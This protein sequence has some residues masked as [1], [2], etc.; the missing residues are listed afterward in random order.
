MPPVSPASRDR[1]LLWTLALTVAGAL[2]LLPFWQPLLLGVWAGIAG[3]GLMRRL[4]PLCRGHENIAATL[5]LLGIVLVAAPVIAAFYTILVDAWSFVRAA[6]ANPEWSQ[7]LTMLVDGS[8]G[9]PKDEAL[10]A[11][12]AAQGQGAIDPA[13]LPP[14][15]GEGSAEGSAEGSGGLPPE[16]DGDFSLWAWVQEEWMPLAQL[17]GARAVETLRYVGGMALRAALQVVT[18]FVVVHGVLTQGPS[19]WRWL[20]DHAPLPRLH[21]VRYGAAFVETGRG[22]VLGMGGAALAQASIAGV[23]FAAVGVQRAL[24]LAVLT[25]AGAFVPGVGASLV[26]MPVAAG[27]ALQGYSERALVVVVVGLTLI[28]T[29]DN[30]LRPVL[31]RYALLQLPTHVVFLTMVGGLLTLGP[32][33]LL[34]GPLLV[35][36]ASEALQIRREASDGPAPLRERTEAPAVAPRVV[37]PAPPT[38]ESGSGGEE[39]GEKKASTLDRT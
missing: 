16:A 18:F 35:R 7:T 4:V 32:V 6:V 19:W 30:V 5:I 24:V 37:P 23:L 20:V 27:L 39:T 12:P 38:A 10:P 1:Q 13:A 22:V 29:I 2:V 14:D 3:R 17:Y 26:W 36:L 15:A 31:A 8:G 9:G 21:M 28:G 34:A 25:F 33:G 11:L